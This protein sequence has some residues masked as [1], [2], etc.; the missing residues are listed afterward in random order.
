MSTINL[1]IYLKNVYEELKSYMESLSEDQRK[2]FVKN[3]HKMFEEGTA[4]YSSRYK[5]AFYILKYA[6]AYGFQFSRAYADIIADMGYPAG[7]SA[8]SIGCGTGIDYWGLSYAVRDLCGVED[9]SLEYTG[10]DPQIWPFRIA[11][12]EDMPEQDTVRYNSVE[13]SAEGNDT[14][15]N[16]FGEY[17]DIMEINA[18]KALDDI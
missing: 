9:C 6:R 14:E 18:D 17:I 12:S 15:C 4:D 3:I 1:K 5:T 7:V 2:E 13:L 8:T 16:N 10:I 11:E